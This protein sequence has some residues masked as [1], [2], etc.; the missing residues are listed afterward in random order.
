MCGAYVSLFFVKSDVFEFYAR[1]D[2]AL[3]FAGMRSRNRKI[4]SIGARVIKRSFVQIVH[5]LLLLLLPLL[6]LT[7]VFLSNGDTRWRRT[8]VY[9]L[10]VPTCLFGEGGGRQLVF[11]FNASHLSLKLNNIRCLVG[12]VKLENDF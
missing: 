3:L 1:S 12:R 6:P 10:F 8:K 4:K 11:K 9:S 5:C 2:A 7:C